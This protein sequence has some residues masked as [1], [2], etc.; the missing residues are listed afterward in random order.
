MDIKDLT[1]VICQQF[2][3]FA[4]VVHYTVCIIHTYIPFTLLDSSGP[5]F[6]TFSVNDCWC[7]LTAL[8]NCTTD[9]NVSIVMNPL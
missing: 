7:L 8:N 2:A 4:N 1:L 3:K 9:R 5:A 6:F